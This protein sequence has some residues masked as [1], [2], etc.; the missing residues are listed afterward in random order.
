MIQT[1]GVADTPEGCAA[2][3]WG[4]D[5][6]QSWTERNIMRF[7]KAKFSPAP[8]EEYPK[9]QHGLGADLLESS[10]VEKDLGALVDYATISG[11][12]SLECVGKSVAT[13]GNPS[14]L[15]CADYNNLGYTA[16]ISP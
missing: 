2:I 8:G 3:Q 11:S 14:P 16:G 9:Y 5:R 1:G 7:N 6:L 13:S 15:E 4:L 10:S 12:G